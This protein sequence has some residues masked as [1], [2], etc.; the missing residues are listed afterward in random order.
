M[1]HIESYLLREKK[2]IQLLGFEDSKHNGYSFWDLKNTDL[3]I[4]KGTKIVLIDTRG[5][6]KKP[7]T[8]VKKV[9]IEKL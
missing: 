5:L 4:L 8:K 3:N 9:W 2:F 6:I 1:S 7:S